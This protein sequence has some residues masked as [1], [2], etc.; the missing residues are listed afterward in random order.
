VSTPAAFDID[1]IMQAVR[2]A[3]NLHAAATTATLLQSHPNRSEVATV[4]SDHAAEIEERAG[5]AAD[6]VPPDYLDAWARLNC[7]KPEGVSDEDWRQALDD[8]G[9]F[10]DQFGN[11]AVELGWTRHELFDVTAG[12]VWR[13]AGE[14]ALGAGTYRVILPQGRSIARSA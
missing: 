8:G 11:E 4:A 5:L 2:A 7:Q 1:A 12:V 10:L 3:A 14:P 13:L 6:R 9:R